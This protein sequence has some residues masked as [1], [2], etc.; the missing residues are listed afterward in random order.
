LAGELTHWELGLILQPQGDSLRLVDS[1]TG[2]VLATSKEYARRIKTQRANLAET[3][4][5]ELQPALEKLR[6]KKN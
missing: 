6:Q 3:K 1:Y 4:I 5:I 2:P